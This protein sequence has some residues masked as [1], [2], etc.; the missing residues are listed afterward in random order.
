[1]HF[2]VPVVALATSAVP[3]TVGGAG[4]LLE[5]RDPV[6]VGSAVHRV[7]SDAGLRERLVAAGRDQVEEFSFDRT[8]KRTLEV[9]A[10]G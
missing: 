9:L 4:L 5:D 6:V 7:L 8:A 10:D 3:E 1:M 2:G